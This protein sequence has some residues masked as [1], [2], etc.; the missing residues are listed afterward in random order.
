MPKK[1]EVNYDRQ[2][3]SQLEETLEKVDKL[4][5]EIKKLKISHAQEIISLKEEIKEAKYPKEIVE[6]NREHLIEKKT[7]KERYAESQK[8][9]KEVKRIYKRELEQKNAAHDEM[10]KEIKILHKEEVTKLREKISSQEKEIEQLKR[11]NK[12]LKDMLGKNSGN[13]SKPPSSDGFRKIQNSRKPTG[14]KP[15]GQHGHK[16][17]QPQYYEKPDRIIEIKQNKCKCGG[18]ITYSDEKY[19]KKQLVDI[20]IKTK[21]I[22]YREFMGVCECCGKKAENHAPIAD[23]ITYGNNVKSISSLLSVEGCVSVNRLR[24]ILS[25]ISG[26]K[27][28]LSEGTLCKWNKDLAKL[29]A[30]S[31]EKIKKKLLK[32]PVLHKDETGIRVDKKLKWFHVLSNKKYSL[33][34]A[35]SKRGK[36]ADIQAGVL[37]GFKGVLVHDN[38]KSL[39]YF[40]DCTHAECNAHILRYL[41]GSVESQNRKW[42]EEMIQF[43]LRAKSAVEER[44]LN[45][46]EITEFHNLYDKILENGETELLRDEEPDYRGEDALLLRRLKEFK[47]QHLLFL[48]DRTVPFDNNQAERDLRMIKAKTKISG[49]FRSAD[50]DSV[51]ATLKSYT[52]TIRKNGLNIFDSLVSAWMNK[53]VFFTNG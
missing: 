27:L 1:L 29:V 10:I 32:S 51:F 31:I 9:L 47:T 11:Q 13:S 42:A 21:V 15:G 40:K 8:K 2:I 45:P 7:G 22:E 49:C 28:N 19:T 25:E 39:Y 52:S 37:Y 4:T 12:A 53:S 17:V 18:K 36:D 44:A 23:R 38:L 20:E 33:F 43:L 24:G 50:G 46:D 34:Y 6:M 14:R 5:E 41:K 16:G 26:G 48:S 30:P 3:Y 35:D